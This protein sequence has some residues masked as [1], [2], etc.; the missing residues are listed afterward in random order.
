[1]IGLLLV[2]VCNQVDLLNMLRCHENIQEE[3]Q[4]HLEK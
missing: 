3:Q 2:L 4:K 1:M